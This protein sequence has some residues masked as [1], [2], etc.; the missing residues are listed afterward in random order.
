[1]YALS[2]S[3]MLLGA[4]ISDVFTKKNVREKQCRFPDI[5]GLFRLRVENW[6]LTV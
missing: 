6:W 5:R 4:E 2:A 1:M 3:A